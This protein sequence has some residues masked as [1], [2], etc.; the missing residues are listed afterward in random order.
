MDILSIIIIAIVL[1]ALLIGYI[2][3][4]LKVIL[5]LFNHLASLIISFFLAKPVGLLLFKTFIGR[6]FSG[7]F[8]PWLLNVDSIFHEAL[9]FENQAEIVSEGLTKLKI[10]AFLHSLVNK[11]L[12]N[13]ITD[14]G[15]NTLGYYLSQSLAQIVCIIIAFLLLT[16]IAFILFKLLSRAFKNVNKAPIIGPFN[17]LLGMVTCGVFALAI[18][19]FVFWLSSLLSTVS[20]EFAGIVNGL[21]GLDNDQFTIAKWLYQNNFLIKL[22]ELLIK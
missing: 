9:T 6:F 10:P 1:I 2:K 7:K 19:W 22:F 17:R 3:G 20:S 14:G 21:L 4:F 15:G 12:G 11:M 18:I 16:I 5:R 8:E 13:L